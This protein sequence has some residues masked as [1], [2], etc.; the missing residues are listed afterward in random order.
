MTNSRLRVLDGWPLTNKVRVIAARLRGKLVPKEQPPPS[1]VTIEKLDL[2]APEVAQ[3]AFP[4]YEEL[5]KLGPVHFLPRN[6]FWLVIGFREVSAALM[7]PEVFSNRVS[8]WMAVDQVLLGADPPEHTAVRRLI[9]PLFSAS[10]LEAQTRFAEEAAQRLLEPMLAGKQIN[11]LR[12]FGLPL[13]EDVV[14]HIIGLDDGTLAQ[15]RALEDEPVRDLSEWLNGLDS[16]IANASHRIP[17]YAALLKESEGSLK[18]QDVRSLIRFLWIAGT[19]TTRRVIASS[20]LMLLKHRELAPRLTSDDS[21]ITGFVEETIRLHPPEHSIARVTKVE[22][23]LLDVKIPAGSVVK[24]CLAAANRD[25]ACFEEPLVIRID[26]TPN[27][28]LSFGGGIHRCLGAGLARIEAI[29]AVRTVLKLA[30]QFRS[31]QPLG[32]LADAGFT[33]DTEELLIEC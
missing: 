18:E 15:I 6:G 7:N 11:V 33:N 20:V 29:A 1:V 31:V 21:S 16:I 28:Q 30:P 26:R 8:E 25:P 19:T 17:L 3:N 2:T 24:L 23:N 32:V 5:R 22:T 13:S 14:A 12:E 10:T 9:A 4:Y 27:R